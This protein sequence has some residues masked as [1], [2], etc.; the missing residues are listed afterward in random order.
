MLKGVLFY[1]K[2]KPNK[3]AEKCT[4]CV[5]LVVISAII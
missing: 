2:G 4:K 1:D 5:T 3:A